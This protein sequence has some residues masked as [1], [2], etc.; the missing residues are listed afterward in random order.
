MN[1]NISEIFDYGDEIVIAE[2]INGMFDPEE[3]KELTMKKIRNDGMEIKK[4][5]KRLRT[6]L[7]AA[8][9]AAACLV[10][11]GAGYAAGLFRQS[12]N[13]QGE[14]VGEPRPA[15]TMSPQD[16]VIEIN[17][18][19]DMETRQAILDDRADRELVIVHEA[20][21]ESSSLRS[22]TVGSVD[23]LAEK[24]AAEDSPLRV[25]WNIPDGYVLTN[26]L[27]SFD[28]LGGYTRTSSEVRDDGLVVD[29]YTA[30]PE[31]DFIS[32]YRLDY[33]NE[34]G[35]RIFI[36]ARMGQE[37]AYGFSATNGETVKAA[38][39]AGMT[40]ALAQWDADS[41]T[42]NMLQKLETP[43]NYQDVFMLM[44]DDEENDPYTEVYYM[45][46]ASGVDG[47]GLMQMVRP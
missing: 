13:W 4:R 38:E 1:K 19:A 35:E 37:S 45:L 11:C 10:L 21:G 44:G 39:V 25:P 23:E 40:E 29:R 43:I 2:E 14:K 24:L 34:D 27:V 15:E 12:Y 6:G 18:L 32:Y 41:A 30:P 17:S 9:V 33:E 31:N 5:G 46:S 47:D 26:G 42:L 16:K 22:E 20:W 28:S 3:I 7:V 8:I 36:F